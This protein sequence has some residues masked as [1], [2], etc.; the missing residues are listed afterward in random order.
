MRNAPR[1]E[2]Q[3]IYQKLGDLVADGSLSAEVEHAVP[4][5]AVQGSV[6]AILRNRIAA[7]RSD[8]SLAR[9]ASMLTRGEN[10][11]L[12]SATRLN[13][14]FPSICYSNPRNLR[15]IR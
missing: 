14:G 12:T 1:T 15:G 7:A 13:R 8:L 9:T 10:A 2:I 5:G 3:E 6:R 4:V 11:D